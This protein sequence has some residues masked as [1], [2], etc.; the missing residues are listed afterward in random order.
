MRFISSSDFYKYRTSMVI[1]FKNYKLF[2]TFRM[3]NIQVNVELIQNWL[4]PKKLWSDW[5]NSVCFFLRNILKQMQKNIPI[6]KYFALLL[7][8]SINW[9]WSFLSLCKQ[10][11]HVSLIAIHFCFFWLFIFKLNLVH[12]LQVQA[13]IRTF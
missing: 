4:Q 8:D 1:D 5:T 6:I 9:P 3:N 7:K 13:K 2:N 10:F 11:S 12:K